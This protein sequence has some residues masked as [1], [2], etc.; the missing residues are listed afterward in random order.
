MRTTAGQDKNIWVH[1]VGHLKKEGLLPAVI[2][3]FSK[4]RCEENAN[5]LSNIDYCNQTEK[6][7]IHMIIEKSLAR[8]RQEDRDL[9]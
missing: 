6:S 4:K 1:L 5:A 9:G 3:V 8:L 2:F 7:A